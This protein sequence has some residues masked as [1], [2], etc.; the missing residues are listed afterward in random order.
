V[1]APLEVNFMIRNEIARVSGAGPPANEA[2]RSTMREKGSP[3][4]DHV[5]PSGRPRERPA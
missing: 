4:D 3:S 2:G 5:A 1:A